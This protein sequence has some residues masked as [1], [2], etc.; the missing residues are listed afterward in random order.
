MRFDIFFAPEIPED[1]KYILF[2]VCFSVHSAKDKLF[3]L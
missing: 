1:E 3:A 2:S